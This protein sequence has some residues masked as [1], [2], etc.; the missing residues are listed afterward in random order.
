[1]TAGRLPRSRI[2]IDRSHSSLHTTNMKRFLLPLAALT[3]VL[4]S[5]MLLADDL[6]AMEGKW[7]VESAE[8]GGKKI[9]VEGL[10]D[11]VITIT[12]DRYELTTK[13]GPD[14]G[15]L[16]LDEAQK[17]KTMDATDTEGENVGK[18]I[19]AVYELS[20][21]TLRVCY[22]MKGDERPKELATSE[23][24]PW[25]LLIYKREK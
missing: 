15:T 10:K 23:G 17:P 4:F 12:G 21:D 16:K 14:A 20:G 3:L 7:K 6:K 5:P 24:S 18:V 22:P 13:D 2:T 9:E 8:A 1:M 25:L 19:K 11:L